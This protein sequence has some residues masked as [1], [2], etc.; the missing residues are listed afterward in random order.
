MIPEDDGG[1]RDIEYSE[2][3]NGT[4]A[5]FL[6]M[7][8]GGGVTCDVHQ[9]INRVVADPDLPEDQRSTGIQLIV[10]DGGT[11]VWVWV[12]DISNDQGLE[13]QIS[14]P[15]SDE[16]AIYVLYNDDERTDT[17]TYE[18]RIAGFP[19][20]PSYPEMVEEPV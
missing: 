9:T 16:C 17:H 13:W 8:P 5:Q 10:N 20:E 15:R 18:V 11:P 12:E 4:H 6:V 3:P 2:G 19:K 7:Y 14:Q 1:F